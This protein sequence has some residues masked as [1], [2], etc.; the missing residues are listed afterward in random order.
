MNLSM[1]LKV[2]TKDGNVIITERKGNALSFAE[3][4]I[5][6]KK[7][8]MITMGEL[9]QLPKQQLVEAFGY[10]TRKTYYDAREAV[11][12][13]KCEDL[14]PKKSGPKKATKRTKELEKKVIKMRFD[15]DL[16]MYGITDELN[17]QGFDIGS[18]LV[19]QILKD[20]DLSKK[21][22]RGK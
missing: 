21:N 19:G 18:S 9:T 1:N 16:N 2:I 12:Q 8:V 13:G 10:T 5:P 20:Y 11:L 14:I 7:V 15:T 17:K 3:D 6:Q 22:V 4:Q